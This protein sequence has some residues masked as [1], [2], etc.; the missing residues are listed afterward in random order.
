MNKLKKLPEFS[1]EAEE[2][3]FWETHD[4]SEY[5]DCSKAERISFPDLKPSTETI[6]FQTPPP[7]TF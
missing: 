6:S 3:I 5:I 4:S 7:E 2:R 1:S